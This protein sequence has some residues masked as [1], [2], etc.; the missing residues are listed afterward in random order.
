LIVSSLL[1]DVLLPY[2]AIAVPM[3]SFLPLSF[4]A[5]RPMFQLAK[6]AFQIEILGASCESKT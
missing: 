4:S 5:P 6:R 2:S 3:A 1:L